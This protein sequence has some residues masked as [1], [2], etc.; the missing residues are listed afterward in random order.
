M[1]KMKNENGELLQ[2]ILKKDKMNKQLSE[3]IEDL[4][5]IYDVFLE[6]KQKV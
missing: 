6:T 5:Q 1:Q 3:K 4:N 2:E